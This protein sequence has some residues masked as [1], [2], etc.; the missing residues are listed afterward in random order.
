MHYIDETLAKG[1]VKRDLRN[2]K[3]NASELMKTLEVIARGLNSFK[4]RDLREEAILKKIKQMHFPFFHRYVPAM[5][6]NSY[7]VLSKV[8]DSDCAVV[9]KKFLKKCQD[10]ESKLLYEIHKQKNSMVNVFV[11]LDDAG[12]NPGSLVI[13][14]FDLHSK[15]KV[16]HSVANI[17]R[18]CL[19]RV[20]QRSGCQTL[21]DALEEILTGLV[22]LELTVRSYITRPSE[23]TNGKNEFKIH[24]P[25]KNGALLLKIEKPEMHDKDAFLNSNL[26]T[27]INKRQFFEEQEVT[28][29][30]FTFVNFINY[31]LNAPNLSDMQKDFQDKVDKLKIEGAFSVEF[32]INGFYYDSAEVMNAINAGDYLD[33][34]IAFERH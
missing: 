3:G 26:V 4:T 11:A 16:C 14:I 13:C 19:E 27:W 1:I 2:W 33:N 25:T 17:S 8:H 21:T 10:S 12:I 24:V 34:I 7:G 31:Q 23:R 9:S 30:H 29:K 18:H 5:H 32:L 15:E 20:V 28:L 22:S 6:S